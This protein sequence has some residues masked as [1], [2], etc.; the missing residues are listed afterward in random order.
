MARGRR[1]GCFFY[2]IL[3]AIGV[4]AYFTNPTEEMHKAAAKARLEKIANE[5]LNKYGVEKSIIAKLGISIS[6]QFMDDMINNQV[7]SDNYYLLSTTKVNWDGRSQII[8]VGVFNHVFISN[9]VDEILKK[10]LENTVKE[11]ING[12]KIPGLNLEDLNLGIEL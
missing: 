3:I 10:E 2:I 8:G 7:S 12:I 11:K 9:K 5:M 6:E 4:A 1:K